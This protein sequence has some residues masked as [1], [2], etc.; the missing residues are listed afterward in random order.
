MLQESQTRPARLSELRRTIPECSKKVLID[1]LRDLEGL[2]WVV[3]REYPS[4]RRW[5]EYS[6]AEAWVTPLERVM[7][8]VTSH[9]E[10]AL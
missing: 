10:Y 4:Q 2:G 3:R 7:S 9:Q 8:D 6:I 1:T 5:V